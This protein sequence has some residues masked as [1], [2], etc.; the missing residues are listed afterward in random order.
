MCCGLCHGKKQLV[1]ERRNRYE[2]RRCPE[3]QPKQQ[4]FCRSVQNFGTEI[5]TT[6]PGVE[7]VSTL[8]GTGH[9]A[10]SGTSMASPAV[11]GFAAHLL[12]TNLN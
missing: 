7:I 9:G 11:A 1:S 6:G 3:G 12:S 10:L 4:G 8:P 2:R 5:D